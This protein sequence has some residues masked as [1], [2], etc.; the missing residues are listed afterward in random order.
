MY[1]YDTYFSPVCDLTLDYASEC[2]H[3]VRVAFA[4]FCKC[5]LQHLIDT[6]YT[7][8]RHRLA[9]L[10]PASSDDIDAIQHIY[11]IFYSMNG[12]Q[13]LAQISFKDS[14]FQL[15]IQFCITYG[16]VSKVNHIRILESKIYMSLALR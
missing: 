9:G 1:L 5:C 14:T 4:N 10:N 6:Q 16:H 2:K 12:H 13:S 7:Q 8:H 15:W 3:T 11:D